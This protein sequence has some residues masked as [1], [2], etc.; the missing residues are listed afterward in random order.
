MAGIGLVA[1]GLSWKQ[2]AQPRMVWSPEQAQ[3]HEAAFNDL[4]AAISA[5]GHGDHEAKPGKENAAP[6][7]SP[8]DV[9]AARER[10][11]RIDGQLQSARRLKT[12]LGPQLARIGL[13]VAVLFGIGYLSSRGD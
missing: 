9:A 4:H 1:V 12:N 8:P 10:F 5:E 2:F 7:A 11:E 3:E 6:S 13:V